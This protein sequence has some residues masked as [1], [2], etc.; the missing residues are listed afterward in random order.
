MFRKEMP[1]ETLTYMVE[2][3]RMC[4]RNRAQNKSST[5][6]FSPLH[7]LRRCRGRGRDPRPKTCPK[8]LLPSIL[9]YRLV[10]DSGGTTDTPG[11]RPLPARHAPRTGGSRRE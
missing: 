4:L 2:D 10:P 9:P 11:A 5:I 8:R 3:L 7:D 1:N 6:V